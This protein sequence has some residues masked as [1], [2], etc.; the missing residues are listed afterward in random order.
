MGRLISDVMRAFRHHSEIFIVVRPHIVL[1]GMVSLKVSPSLPKVW[2]NGWRSRP[3]LESNHKYL[4]THSW[5]HCRASH[6]T[7]CS[8]WSLLRIRLKS[9]KM[10]N[11]VLISFSLEFRRQREQVSLSA[12]LFISISIYAAQDAA[13]FARIFI[14]SWHFFRPKQW[15]TDMIMLLRHCTT[16]HGKPFK[17]LHLNIGIWSST[18]SEYGA[19]NCITQQ[20]ALSIWGVAMRVIYSQQNRALI[21]VALK[22]LSR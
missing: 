5:R 13:Y 17:P 1:R 22:F 21:N 8:R 11:I 18:R 9:N 16:L 3:D 4:S 6:S 12:S 14:N 2:R 20:S 15:S 19:L 10:P 7:V